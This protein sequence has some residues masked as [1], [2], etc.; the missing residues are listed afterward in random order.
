MCFEQAD[1]DDGVVL[2]ASGAKSPALAR[3]TRR[4]SMY[5]LPSAKFARSAVMRVTS[6]TV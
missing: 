4:T 3:S 2:P 1:E 6:E 5:G